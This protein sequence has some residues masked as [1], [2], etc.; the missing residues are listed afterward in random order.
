MPK[1]QPQLAKVT[2]P[3]LHKA[4]ARERLFALL[5]EA[6]EHRPAT[7]VVAPPGAGKTTLVASW[8]DARNLKGIWYQVDPGDADLATFIYYLGEAARPFTRKGQRPLPALTPE[9]LQDVEGFSRRFFRELFSRM[10]EDATLVLDNLQDVAPEQEFHQVIA[11]AV[12]EVPVGMTLIAISRHDPPGAYARL[13]ANASVNYIDWEALKFNLEEASQMAINRTG[14][15]VNAMRKLHDQ[16]DGWAAGLTLL[17]EGWSSPNVV[18]GG[19]RTGT[20]TLFNYFAAQIFD[21]ISRSTQEFLVTTAFLSQ[22]PV[23]I[24]VELTGNAAAGK[25]LDDLYRRHLFTHR[26][27]STEPVYWYHALFREFLLSRALELLEVE[28]VRDVQRRAARLL[29][30]RGSFEE[31]FDLYS[32]A[33]DWDAAADLAIDSAESMLARG[34]NQMLRDWIRAFPESL[35]VEHPRL[36]YLLGLSLLQTDPRDA[37]RHLEFSVRTF[38]DQ[39]DPYGKSLAVAAVIDS[40]FYEW[41]DFRPVR[42]WLD[43]LEQLVHRL[44]TAG[45]PD[46]ALKLHASLLV[47]MLYAAPDHPF[48]PRAVRT[49]AESLKSDQDINRMMSIGIILLSYCNLSGD[50]ELGRQVVAR[51]AQLVDRIELTPINALWWHLRLGYHHEL[52][53]NYGEARAALDRAIQIC[54]AHGFRGLNGTFLLIASYQLSTAASDGRAEDARMWYERMITMADPGRPMDAWHLDESRAH[55]ESL[56]GNYRSVAEIGEQAL[57]RTAAAGMTYIEVL[58]IVNWGIG[59]AML[60]D[61]VSLKEAMARLRRLTEKTCFSYFEC[62]ARLTE[63]RL[64][65][66]HGRRQHGHSLLADGLKLARAQRFTYPQIV[67]FAS[68]VPELFAE[69]LRAGIESD[70]VVDTIRRLRIRPPGRAPENWPWPI[71]IIA[72]GGFEVWRD[73]RRLTFPGKAPRK[74]LALLKVMIAYGGHDVPE[75]RITDALWPGEDADLA[76]KNLDVTLARLRKLLGLPQSIMFNEDMFSLNP[77]LF[78]TDVW[79]FENAAN[80]AIGGTQANGTRT[81]AQNA[82]DFYR[83]DFLPADEAAPWVLRK[84]ERLRST[85]LRTVQL[86]GKRLEEEKQWEQAIACYERGID[87]DDLAEP[88]YQ[89]LMR[90][91]RKLDRD[92][93]A[94]VAYRRLRKLLSVVLGMAPSE[95]TQALARTLQGDNPPAQP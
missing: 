30:S 70:Y 8:L 32:A 88:F 21:Q 92:A 4:V 61:A 1:K 38:D 28:S 59:R 39:E 56:N 20:E 74:P 11:Q 9:Y 77:D 29:E 73:G 36:S 3:R 22:V 65:L 18:S 27:V 23:S 79:A 49:V 63:A 10:P 94:M 91:Y 50:M 75:Y 40:Y 66:E 25:I 76:A 5:D 72:L 16:S 58:T 35:Y 55:L 93:E 84:R 51:C 89:G 54:E 78:W 53:G 33:A 31:A 2:R 48:L 15:S 42:P 26:R 47:G 69:A 90:C 83:G 19:R 43:M 87:S 62:A 7:Y 14:L 6:R 82:I 60:G 17:I 46:V 13:V 41:S 68:M 67:R 64:A 44:Q 57:K 12:E 45:Q 85:F 37:R 81:T 80:E 52:S 71:R 24:A 86:A 95:P 34:R